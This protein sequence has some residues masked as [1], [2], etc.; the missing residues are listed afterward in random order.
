[1]EQRFSW[2]PLL[3]RVEQIAQRWGGVSI[4]ALGLVVYLS[5]Q[6]TFVLLPILHRATLIEPDDAYSYIVKAVQIESCFLQDSPALNDLRPQIKLP[7]TDDKAA[8]QR[9]RQYRLFHQ[10]HP[11]HSVIL[12][13]LH[14]AGLTWETGYNA[15]MV[16]GSI[17]IGLGA[18]LWLLSLWG[19]GPAGLALL[20]LAFNVFPDQGLHYVVP[21]NMT[22][23][24]ALWTWTAILHKGA[25]APWAVLLGIILMVAM[26]PLG[27]FYGMVAVF[28]YLILADRSKIRRVWIVA[29]VSLILIAIPT[30]LPWIVTRPALAIIHDPVPQGWTRLQGTKTNVIEAL[31]RVTIWA[32][33]DRH[34]P[35]DT[36][37]I[38][39]DLA[40]LVIA[41]FFV[42]SP[43]R[44]RKILP[45]GLLLFPLLF[46]DFVFIHVNYPTAIFTRLFIPFAILLT[47]AI[48]QVAWFSLGT[49]LTWLANALKGSSGDPSHVG[50]TVL[51]NGWRVVIVILMFLILS[52][53][54]INS[55][56]IKVQRMIETQ[57]GMRYRWDFVFDLKQPA[58]LVQKAR[59][60][61]RV[62]YTDEATLGLYLTHG[63]FVTGS[64]YIPALRN[65]PEEKTWIHENKNIRYLA[66]F[67]P[68]GALPIS[69]R[70]G[71]ALPKKEKIE[72]RTTAASP[73]SSLLFRFVNPAGEAT[74][75]VQ[76]LT[77]SGVLDESTS[78]SL[79][80]P[81]GFSGWMPCTKDERRTIGRFTLELRKGS[82]PFRVEG[83]RV[84]DDLAFN[85][86]WDQGVSLVYLPGA[87]RDPMF[88][89]FASNDLCP[90]LKRPIRVLMDTGSTVLA[91]V[92]N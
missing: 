46:A 77:P 38:L 59:E 19:A 12:W 42:V 89:S 55:T 29:L 40:F 31:R 60:G 23:G 52:R 47:G 86:P 39:T 66:V 18:A 8:W 9:F 45:M 21:S 67:N 20:L 27:R 10:Y 79:V 35:M 22:L 24:L 83:I 34:K 87:D 44:R 82:G 91:E 58:L 25:L 2:Q 30:I 43:E 54:T 33:L 63:A 69:S 16:G 81:S 36:G 14:K 56:I 90:D 92:G 73:L 88:A 48:G 17:L 75:A 57:S 68:I 62:A 50:K 41:G 72:V 26:H 7:T 11:L 6:T 1:M 71:L 80:I 85:W 64:V 53:Y 3:I 70:N 78:F 28:L 84:G 51:A 37:L 15:I 5:V 32:G 76:G 74:L 61:D 13:S 49:A 4:F 65:T